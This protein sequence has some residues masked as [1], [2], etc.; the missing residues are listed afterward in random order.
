M[1]LQG[2]IAELN[3]E[4]EGDPE[5]YYRV[6]REWG[7]GCPEALTVRDH[8]RI[9]GRMVALVRRNG[10]RF[11]QLTELVGRLNY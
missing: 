8:L 7:W 11:E 10:A 3:R 4:R 9:E 5:A 1:A 2:R 6:S